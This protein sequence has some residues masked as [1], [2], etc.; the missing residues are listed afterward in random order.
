MHGCNII[1]YIYIIYT[2]YIYIYII[3]AVLCAI[4]T[5]DHAVRLEQKGGADP[6]PG[7]WC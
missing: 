1:I 6:G 3:Y 7:E 4:N 5:E 2:I